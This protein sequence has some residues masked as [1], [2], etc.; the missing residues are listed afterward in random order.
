MASAY[1]RL[2][3]Y[4]QAIEIYQQAL[5]I[6]Q[7]IPNNK[8]QESNIL[9]LMAINYY[10][11]KKY[12]QAIEIHKQAL[13][14]AQAIP[15]NK[16]EESEILSL[17]AINYSSLGNSEQ[18]IKLH[19]QAL[20]IRREIKDEPG[21]LKSLTSI[22]IRYSLKISNAIVQGLY[23]QATAEATKLIE[24]AQEIVT[25]SIK[26]EAPKSQATALI[27]LGHAYHVL[28]ENQKAIELLTQAVTIARTT[29]DL[30]T[31]Y[32]ALGYFQSVYNTTGNYVQKIEI[33]L[34]QL[35]I[36]REQNK[37]FNEAAMLSSLG[38][39]YAIIGEHEKAIEKLQ[40]G[41][42]IYQ[43]IETEPKVLQR[44][45]SVL[46]SLASNYRTVGEYSKAMDIAQQALQLAKTSEQPE[47]LAE[48]LLNLA[49]F[50]DKISGDLPKVIE[51]SQQALSIAQ[52][53]KA[54]QIQAN[55]LLKLSDANRQQGNY[56]QGLKFAEQSLIIARQLENPYLEQSALSTLVDIYSNQGNY[57]KAL[58]FAQESVKVVRQANLL[59]YEVPILNILSQTYLNLGNSQKALETANQSLTLARQQ[60]N[61]LLE[62]LA[63]QR[64]SVIYHVRGE[65]E[66]S[67]EA[68]QA[69][70]DIA[71]QSK[72]LLA[73]SIA[74]SLLSE[75]YGALGQT[76]KVIEVAEP[77]LIYAQKRNNRPLEADLLINL[78]SAYDTIGNYQ[79]A[80][81][82]VEQGLLI[83]KELKNPALESKALSRLGS[84]Y[85]SQK[86]YQKALELT[87]KSLDIAQELKSPPL[88][89]FPLFTLGTIYAELGDYKKNIELYQQVV[90]ITRKLDNRAGEGVAL[91]GMGIAYFYQGNTQKTIENGERVITIAQEI[92]RADFTA[93]AQILLTMGYGELGND[94]KAIDNAQSFLKYA[95]QVENPVS[96]KA[97]LAVL[98]S[99]HRKFGR[100]QE[101]INHYQQALAMTIEGQVSD[102]DV[103]GIYGGLAR[104]YRDLNQPVTAIGYYKQSINTIEKIRTNIEGLSP[105]LQKSFINAIYDFDKFTIADIYRE[106][107]A[108][109][110]SQGR[111]IEAQQVL[112][113]LK[114]QEISE[115]TRG[116]EKKTQVILTPGEIEIQKKEGTLIAFGQ[117]VNECERQQCAEL[118]E[119]RNQRD[120][121]NREFAQNIQE[122]EKYH[123]NKDPNLIYPGNFL[124]A[125]QK[126]VKQPSTILIYPLVLEDK[127]WI[128]W[129]SQ[130][131][132][133]KTVE[134]KNVDK[135]Q[136]DAT[137][138]KFRDLL[139][140]PSSDI[141]EIKTTGKQLYDWL[142]KP[143]ESEIKANKI[144]NLVFSLDRSTRYIPMNALFDGQ[145]YLVENYNVSTVI[146]AGLTN[147]SDRLPPNIDKTQILALGLSDA[148]SGFN[149]LPNVLKE[150][151]AI[152]R[153]N[154]KESQGIYPGLKF[155]NQEFTWESLRDNLQGKKILHIATHGEFV[156]KD[157]QASYLLL[158]N[159]KKL[160]IA[161][162]NLLQSWDNTHLVV[163]SACETA[164]GGANQNGVEIS[165]I[166]SYFLGTNKAQ[167]VIA[168]LWQVNDASTSQLMQKFYSNLAKNDSPTKIQALRQAQLNLL[169][170]N[171]ST[172]N[173]EKE[174]RGINVE[175]SPDAPSRHQRG[176]SGYSHPYYWG[177]FILIG[178][179]L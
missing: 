108:L 18:A 107:A 28:N 57:T 116:E 145:Q 64:L 151:N 25:L 147:M 90:E 121:L 170:G 32:L 68:A 21:Q 69:M 162:I 88:Q 58:E 169:Q 24:V 72:D 155:L 120:D 45:I 87:Q 40:Q 150:V 136:L 144:E 23:S 26:L 166:S 12:E 16:S 78:G 172:I 41:L 130:G 110:L 157:P 36:A 61:P 104:V 177:A 44:K 70:S 132:I 174:P 83:A 163:L 6:A 148:K 171:N 49:G 128:L 173:S 1:N 33:R 101:A 59:T 112:E 103:A 98:G 102:A 82:L 154:S 124:D 156:P 4:E 109:L 146:S 100:T 7:T 67:I 42:A 96:E 123:D 15:D 138:A 51:L 137:V 52:E 19:Q 63:L 66:K 55:A 114:V 3:K 22:S 54:P 125:A 142:I 34:R 140:N 115:F 153:T 50:Y 77:A 165:G 73:N 168:S 62:S 126:I 86:D 139:E 117:R 134:V 11:L 46:N 17:M 113:L 13:P 122:I 95:R 161:D 111:N 131:V 133:I 179:S 141:A 35:E 39:D 71:Q 158:G 89:L 176:A 152:V 56:A 91:F 175:V 27:D 118:K 53:I 119:L 14:I 43:S 85:N 20:A 80:L 129:A 167:A 159:G 84:I 127:I 178:N 105:Q 5:P 37:K 60:K 47:L 48:S 81:E 160:P 106:L 9:V 149:A 30:D 97:I 38:T 10:R 65:W 31:E 76:N 143:I 74:A 93:L 2:K 94:Q 79:K 135:S 92:N 99:L 8:S 29:K 75:N 164:R